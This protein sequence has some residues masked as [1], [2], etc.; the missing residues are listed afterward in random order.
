MIVAMSS[1]LNAAALAGS[2]A[3]EQHLAITLEDYT[4]DLDQAH[5]NALGALSLLPDIQRA[6][7]ALRAA[8]GRRAGDR[9]AD[10]HLRFRQRGAA[11]QPDVGADEGARGDDRG[12]ARNRPERR[13]R[14]G[15]RISRRCAGWFRRP[16]AIAQRSDQFA[17]EAVEACRRHLRART[18]VDRAF[19]ERRGG[20]PL[21][22][23]HRTGGGR[24]HPSISPAGRTR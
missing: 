14:K 18:D 3:V 19:G 22:R 1:W 23:L 17:A 12:V 7:R 24:R 9:R 13:S 21:G 15:R 2:A 11:S 5:G 10:R 16:G 4:A 20:R 6:S 8:R